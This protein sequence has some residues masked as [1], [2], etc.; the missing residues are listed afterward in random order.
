MYFIN[1][2]NNCSEACLKIIIN[3]IFFENSNNELVQAFKF[4]FLKLMNLKTKNI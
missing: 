2:T 4:I 3:S 1:S